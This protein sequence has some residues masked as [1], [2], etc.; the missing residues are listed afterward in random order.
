MSLRLF[1]ALD[2]PPAARDALAAAGAAADRDIWRPVAPEALHITLAFLG[3]RPPDDVSVIQPILAGEDGRP[4]PR[5]ALGAPLL[6]PPRRARVLTVEVADPD[7]TLHALQARV[8]DAL[9]R[10]GVYTPEQRPFRAHVTIGRLR[11]RVKPPREAGIALEP[12]AFTGEA[13]TLYVSRLHPS[14]ARYEAL[15]RAALI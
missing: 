8:S 4:A 13:V 2:L 7:G 10:A 15:G 6:L 12:V 14:G 1:V 9:A 3:A 11:P 5:L